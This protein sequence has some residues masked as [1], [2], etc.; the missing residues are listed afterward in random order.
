MLAAS[1]L[2]LTVTCDATV[3]YVDVS[4]TNS[5]P[6]YLSWATAAT[7]IQDAVDAAVA[8]DQ[9]LVTNGVYAV[10][11]TAVFGTTS[12]RVAVTKPLTVR[13]VSGPAVT[14]IQGSAF[15]RCAYLTNG[16]V[17]S[18]FTLS[19]A[20]LWS[21]IA[22]DPRDTVGGGLFCESASAVA[23]NCVIAGN[24]AESFGG[25]A[26]GGTLIQCT[27]MG[28]FVGGNGGGACSNTLIRCTVTNNSAANGGGAFECVLE[29][30]VVAGN[31]A[32]QGSGGGVRG[33]SLNFCVL[34]GNSTAGDGGGGSAARL[35]N[36]I[37]TNNWA[38]NGGGASGSILTSCILM[39]NRAT[40]DVSGMGFGG[41]ALGGT[42]NNC[43]LVGNKARYG[44]GASLAKL[45]NSIAYFNTATYD[46]PNFY[47]DVPS[48]TLNYCC[49]W[50]MPASGLGNITNAPL[51]IDLVGGNL[52]LQPN[53]PCINS[54]R[55]AYASAGPDLDGNLR[56]TGG[57]VDI[58]AYE[59][60]SPSSV[61]SYAWAQQYGLPTDGSA[62]YSDADTDRMNNWQEWIT[63]TVPTDP[64][65]VLRMLNPTTGAS[66][67]TVGWQS[68]SN[69]T[70]F[71]ERAN[72]LGA[73]PPLSLLTSN[74]T[75]QVGT[76]SFTDTNAVGSGP[77]FYRV[78]VQQ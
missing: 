34:T 69:R 45:N 52:H 73:T 44:G 41:G 19:S 31:S 33:G 72:D 62:D 12:N 15:V 25:G 6:P 68:V 35:T 9:I 26:H 71:L 55:N 27:L 58:G 51:F 32:F 22:L 76:T 2:A 38:E 66:G 8:G 23:S 47:Q 16:A 49:T 18:G 48:D 78:S 56:I 24:L 5:T 3:R 1:L 29:E 14:T 77:F 53:S 67:V 13:S 74:I 43:T 37:V 39:G 21:D 17:L 36:C 10:G 59:F 60:Q 54:G 46:G 40:N 64:S 28:N 42:L 70:Y 65:S 30:S 4:S 50:P 63:G 57:T 7:N 11:G 20:A 75:G 61:L